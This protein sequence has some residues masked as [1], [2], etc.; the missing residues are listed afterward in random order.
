MYSKNYVSVSYYYHHYIWD[1]EVNLQDQ[2]SL[3]SHL[4]GTQYSLSK[5][6]YFC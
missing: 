4:L 1:L 2:Y 3:L 6:S 5:E